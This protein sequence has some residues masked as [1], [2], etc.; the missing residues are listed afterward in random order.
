MIK[1]LDQ[2][3]YVTSEKIYHIFQIS[4]AVE[5]ALLKCD[6]FPPLNRSASAIQKSTSTFYGY[7]DNSNLAAV[8]DLEEGPILE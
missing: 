7:F 2:S 1:A 5:A 8:M 6:D 4:Y 3:H